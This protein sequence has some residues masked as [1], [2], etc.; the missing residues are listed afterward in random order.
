MT[1]GYAD[2]T[3]RPIPADWDGNGTTTPGITRGNTWYLRN[4]NSNGV[5]DVTLVFGG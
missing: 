4:N 3:D 5:A 2:E 1:V